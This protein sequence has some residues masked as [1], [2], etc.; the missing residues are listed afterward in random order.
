VVQYQQILV[1][2]SL[3]LFEDAVFLFFSGYKLFKHPS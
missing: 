3:D 2:I 1:Q